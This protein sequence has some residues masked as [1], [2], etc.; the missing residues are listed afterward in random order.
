MQYAA[1]DARAWVRA[2]RVIEGNSDGHGVRAQ[3]VLP[4]DSDPLR[5]PRAGC[6]SLCPSP[7]PQLGFQ[8][9][10]RSA[11]FWDLKLIRDEVTSVASNS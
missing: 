7:R 9:H 4:P 11:G 1:Q 2:A 10:V 8:L 6:S 3:A 5:G